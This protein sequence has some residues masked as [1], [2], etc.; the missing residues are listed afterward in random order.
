MDQHI[1]RSITDGLR[2]REVEVLTAHE[3]GA[4]QFEDDQL[5]PSCHTQPRIFHAP[6][7]YAS[8]LPRLGYT[9]PSQL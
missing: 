6:T 1:A 7:Q 3:D 8:N 2:L 4:S 5:S 9:Q